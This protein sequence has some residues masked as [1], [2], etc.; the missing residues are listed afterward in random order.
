MGDVDI[1]N[2]ADNTTLYS[3]NYTK[4]LVINELDK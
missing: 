1:A 2:H 4:E 3:L